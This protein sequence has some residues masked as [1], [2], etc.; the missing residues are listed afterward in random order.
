MGYAQ[1][2]GLIANSCG[3]DIQRHCPDAQ[4]ANFGISTCLEQHSSQVS[5]Q[6]LENI[7]VA[8]N[9]IS[10]RLAAQASYPRA[11]NGDMRQLCPS[12]QRKQGYT[13]QCLLKA[14][15]AVSKTCNQAITDAGWR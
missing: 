4:L 12:I 1:A 7:Q 13:L 8:K 9:A 10:A 11:C 14:E 2:I 5:P 3:Q 6:C 15:R